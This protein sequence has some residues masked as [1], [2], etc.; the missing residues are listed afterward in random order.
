MRGPEPAWTREIGD[1]DPAASATLATMTALVEGAATDYTVR[2][3]AEQIT[4]GVPSYDDAGVVHRL[5]QYVH[6]RVRY[7][8]DPHGVELV[9]SPRAL[10]SEIARDGRGAGDCDDQAVLLAALLRS[11]GF[12]TRFLAVSQRADGDL[13][14]V[15]CAVQ[16]GRGWLTLDPILP[17]GVFGGGIGGPLNA[18]RVVTG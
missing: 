14:H 4:D 5:Y 8:L 11:L 13:H 3:A 2:R 9:K 15:L 10:L 18:L 1:G 17:G 6:H 7:R 12:A 16:F